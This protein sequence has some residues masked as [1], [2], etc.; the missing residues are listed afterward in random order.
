MAVYKRGNV[1]WYKFSYRGE[2][3]R[4]STRQRNKRVAEQIEAAH[5]TGLAK[6]EVGIRD[7]KP[8]PTLT[9]FAQKDF[10]PFAESTFK[11]KA[12]TL[13][14]YTNGVDRLL[15]YDA[16]AGEKLDNINSDKISGYV[17]KRQRTGLQISSINR[18]L[19]VLRRMFHLAQEWGKV[20]KVL[21][22][23]TML[24]GE[25]H[26]ERVLSF[27]EEEQ[28]LA[29]A[30]PLVRDVD[31]I[32]LDCGLRPEECFRLS[33]EN[34]RDGNLEI[35]FGKSG[36]AR[37]RIPMTP[38]VSALL[39]MRKAQATSEWVFPAPTK[40][41]HIEPSS[42]KKQHARACQESNV[43]PFELYCLRHTCLTRWA[44]HMDPWTLAYLAGHRDMSI[45]KRYIHPQGDTIRTEGTRKCTGWAQNQAHS[46]N[47]GD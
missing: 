34:I 23:V 26:R 30:K 45:T 11:A 16:L 20:E 31:T 33:W 19:Q 15:D 24:P 9:E 18:E 10:L 14:Y 4:E 13:R 42:L 39:E 44:P 36:A 35:H 8:V 32:L 29:K 27:E 12:K 1:W 47:S 28:Y 22:K 6:G 25:R 3:I 46:R 7:R 21:P 5:K 41:G 2:L 37:R 43:E 38:R 40:S 17:A